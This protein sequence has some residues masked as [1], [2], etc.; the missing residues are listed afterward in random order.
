M[1]FIDQT[2]IER[3]CDRFP[4]AFRNFILHAND[5]Q[6]K[7]LPVLTQ[8]GWARLHGVDALPKG[9]DAALWAF[10]EKV[11][12]G[13]GFRLIRLITRADMLTIKTK[14]AAQ[15]EELADERRRAETLRIMDEVEQG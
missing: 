8:L 5:C 2:T 9:P 14:D 1:A 12:C 4:E 15:G 10:C 11:L 3:I 7:C 6:E 13:E